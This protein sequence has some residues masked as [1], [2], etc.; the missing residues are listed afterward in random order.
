M[1]HVPVLLKEM[2]AALAPQDGEVYVDAT[3]G[4]GGYT[5]A[6]LAAANCQVIAID[7]DPEAAARAVELQKQFPDRLKYFSATFSELPEVMQK[8][9][10][11]SPHGVVF[12]FGVSSFQIDQPERGFSFRFNGPLDMRMSGVGQTAADVVN[13]YAEDELANIIYHY[14]EERQSRRI[15]KAIIK[16]RALE[17]LT[18]TQQ[19]ADLVKATIKVPPQAQHPATLTFQ[20]LRIFVNNELMEI[21]NGLIFAEKFLE[22]KGRLVAVTFHSLEDRLVKTFIKERAATTKKQSR[23]LPGEQQLVDIKTLVD[24]YPKGIGASPAE[25]GENPRSRSARLRAA[26]KQPLISEAC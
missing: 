8:A 22:V 23:L 19:L 13:T 14:G 5:K 20:A 9:G 16:A 11:I 17:P 26:I 6:I 2:L 25:I 21:K 12:D 4:G 3:F 24:V 1:T 10:V 7:R 18:T 15:A